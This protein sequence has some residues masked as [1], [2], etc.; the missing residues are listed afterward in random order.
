[1]TTAHRRDERRLILAGMAA[2]ALA[3]G[4]GRFAFT[5]LLPPMRAEGLVT[6]SGGG[7]LA[8]VHFA[9]YLMGALAGPWAGARPRAVLVGSLLAI[10]AATLAMGLTD[11]FLAWLALRWLCGL[12]SAFVLVLVGGHLVSRLAG[13]DGA[14][15]WVFAGVGAGI[16]LAGLGALAL[17]AAGAGSAR[18]WQGFGAASLVL[19]VVLALV[20]G[21]QLPARG[22]VAR[23]GGGGRAPL[24]WP[25]VLAYG[26]MGLG[27]IIPA[28][29]LPV[30]ARESV[31]DPLVFG[32]SWPLFGLAAF[33]STPVAARL[34]RRFA[35]RRVWA[36]GQVVMAGGLLAPALWP[37]LAAIVAGGVAVG[38]TFMVITMAGMQEAHRVAPPDDALRHI[39]AMTAAFAA[40]QMA[41]PP[42]A[43][44]VHDAG[45][46]FAGPLA[47][48]ALVLL[49]TAAGLVRD[50]RG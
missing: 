25:L 3:M 41:G 47:V 33:A 16:A 38:G 32:W 6:L 19:A 44:L 36:V 27:Y 8:G 50:R 35:A 12:C 11:S 20:L 48:T 22:A 23:R 31:P 29:Y 24:S 45:G 2:L 21:P 28:T 26:A 43:G 14:Q 37:G 30:M 10:A 7:V 39:A 15:G 13:R 1:M 4:I 34:R 17:M 49:A 9:G 40:G 42:L 46:G 5:P 18:G